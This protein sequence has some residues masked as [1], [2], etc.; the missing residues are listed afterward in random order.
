MLLDYDAP[1]AWPSDV[2]AY[3]A[4]HAALFDDWHGDQIFATPY[5]YDEIVSGLTR[6]L[7]SHEILAWHCTRLTHNET[8]HILSHGMSLPD[9]ASLKPRMSRNRDNGGHVLFR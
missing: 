4:E 9:L 7:V 1:H 3:L 6:I 8:Q 2:T 5:E